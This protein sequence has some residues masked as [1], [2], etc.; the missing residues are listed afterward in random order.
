M[1][2]IYLRKDDLSYMPVE[3]DAEKVLYAQALRQ[4]CLLVFDNGETFK[5]GYP[6]IEFEKLVAS[7]GKY[8]RLH[9]SYLALKKSIID[10]C[11]CWAV[12]D[13]FQKRLPVGRNKF[14]AVQ[15]IVKANNRP[16]D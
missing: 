3:R 14:A 13:K 5:W 8:F 15:E 2:P 12:L 7:T 4:K 10:C 9:D 16:A 1:I 6:L 11:W